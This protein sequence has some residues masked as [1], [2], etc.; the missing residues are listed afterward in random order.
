MKSRKKAVRSGR[1][2]TLSSSFSLSVRFAPRALQ[3]GASSLKQ[4]YSALRGDAT[5]TA[6]GLSRTTDGAQTRR[7]ERSPGARA[8]SNHAAS[9]HKGY[10][11][12]QVRPAADIPCTP[13]QIRLLLRPVILEDG[14]SARTYRSE[15]HLP[16]KGASPMWHLTSRK[17]PTGK[18]SDAPQRG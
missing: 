18:A 9:V 10:E 7:A 12:I 4:F 16:G 3:P 14:S 1:M 5:R 13:A 6:S 17:Q 11:M 15:H 2:T 8:V